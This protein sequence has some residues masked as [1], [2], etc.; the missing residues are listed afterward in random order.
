[1]GMNYALTV[2]DMVVLAIFMTLAV[3]VVAAWRDDDDE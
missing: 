3:A 1:M 2:A